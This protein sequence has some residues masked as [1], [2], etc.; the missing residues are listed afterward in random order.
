MRVQGKVWPGVGMFR[1]GQM[2]QATHGLDKGTGNGAGVDQDTSEVQ[3]C[4]QLWMRVQVRHEGAG[5][6]AMWMRACSCGWM[7][8]PTHS[9]DVGVDEEQVWMKAE[10]MAWAWIRA[11]E[12]HRQGV[13]VCTGCR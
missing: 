5:H 10:G 7:V 9:M 8:W 13:R 11:W 1:H 4:A 2:M 3:G 12:R 6:G